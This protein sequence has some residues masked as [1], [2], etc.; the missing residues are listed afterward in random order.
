MLA[1]GG[2]EGQF[3]RGKQRNLT[4]AGANSGYDRHVSANSGYDR[5]IA[6]R[7]GETAA[8]RVDKRKPTGIVGDDRELSAIS[9]DYRQWTP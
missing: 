6:A 9:G 4:E 8:K 2:P 3:P 1:Y 5:Q 7:G